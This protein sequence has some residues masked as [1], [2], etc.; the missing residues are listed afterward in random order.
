MSYEV[1][2]ARVP[3]GFTPKSWTDNPSWATLV[4]LVGTMALEGACDFC[5]G[6]NTGEIERPL[7]RVAGANFKP[8]AFVFRP[9]RAKQGETYGV[10]DLAA[11]AENLET[12]PTSE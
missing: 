9:G 1:W 8:W 11:L 4:A 12:R 6:F 3:L 2:L 7:L 10:V 5:R